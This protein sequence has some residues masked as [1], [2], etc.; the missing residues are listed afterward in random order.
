MEQNNLYDAGFTSSHKSPCICSL[1]RHTHASPRTR[2]LGSVWKL[3]TLPE[4]ISDAPFA[5][6]F[7]CLFASLVQ[8]GIQLCKF[9]WST[10]AVGHFCA[11]QMSSR[12]VAT[13]TACQGAAGCKDG[14]PWTAHNNTH[15]GS[16]HSVSPVH[17][18]RINQSQDYMSGIPPVSAKIWS[19]IWCRHQLRLGLS[20]HTP[21]FKFLSWIWCRYELQSADIYIIFNLETWNTP[22]SGFEVVY[23]TRS[24]QT[25]S[26]IIIV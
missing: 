22:V 4:S 23:D 2:S 9:M 7:Y 6:G 12:L 25:L 1:T 10:E 11:Q 21:Y 16:V 3:L 5:G 8:P 14:M 15:W 20:I 19:C 26:C 24:F 18:E 17:C 13:W